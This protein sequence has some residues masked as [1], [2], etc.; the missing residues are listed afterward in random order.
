MPE[1][2]RGGSEEAQHFD[3]DL[4]FFG[5]FPMGGVADRDRD[6]DGAHADFTCVNFPSRTLSSQSEISRPAGLSG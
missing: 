4:A 5:H 2:R 1:L 6:A 3:F